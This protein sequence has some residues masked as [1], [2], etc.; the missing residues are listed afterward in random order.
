M[1]PNLLPMWPESTMKDCNSY[2]QHL[3]NALDDL[4]QAG[5]S[6]DLLDERTTK[7]NRQYFELYMAMARVANAVEAGARL[8]DV[9]RLTRVKAPKVLT[10]LLVLSGCVEKERRARIESHMAKALEL[11][12]AWLGGRVWPTTGDN[13]TPT[14]ER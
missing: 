14:R 8:A 6:R 13:G 10:D 4:E 9:D 7:R 11:A 2:A 5:Q 1:H 12:H 3:L